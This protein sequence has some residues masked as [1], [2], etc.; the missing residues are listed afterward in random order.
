MSRRNKLT[1]E[2]HELKVA[3]N[4]YKEEMMEKKR[5]ED[6]VGIFLIVFFFEVNKFLD[7]RAGRG[8]S[9]VR[10]RITAGQNWLSSDL[11]ESPRASW[12]HH[13]TWRN[14]QSQGE[15]AD[16]ESQQ[17]VNLFISKRKP[18]KSRSSKTHIDFL[19]IKH[20]L[21]CLTVL[22]D[23]LAALQVDDQT[24]RVFI[25]LLKSGWNFI[26]ILF[27]F[28]WLD[29]MRT[30]TNWMRAS[31]HSRGRKSTQRQRPMICREGWVWPL[32]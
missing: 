10:W 18:W 1:N 31:S 27:N 11:P 25:F 3:E 21:Q 7:C 24:V 13:G 16:G 22:C 12:L 23:K 2:L 14:A 20:A 29:W 32:C 15:G 30:A 9:A 6:T 8:G 28:R 17:L 26:N 5:L 19:G 4:R